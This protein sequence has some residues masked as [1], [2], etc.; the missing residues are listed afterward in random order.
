MVNLQWGRFSVLL[1]N[2]DAV[3]FWTILGYGWFSICTLYIC[4]YIFRD[5][6]LAA[7]YLMSCRRFIPIVLW[8]WLM[9]P[10]VIFTVIYLSIYTILVL[11]S[12]YSFIQ[13]TVSVILVTWHGLKECLMTSYMNAFERC[14]TTRDIILFF[15][16]CWKYKMAVISRHA[17]QLSFYF[18]FSW[19]PWCWYEYSGCF[20][21]VKLSLTIR[22]LTYKKS[23]QIM[24][25]TP[26]AY[27][28]QA[29]SSISALTN[30]R[31]IT[32]STF[33]LS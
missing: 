16:K 9:D 23:R 4:S 7:A 17:K 14:C 28:K 27:Y 30:W 25:E 8:M 3:V 26:L 20:R 5:N 13:K 29:V 33:K 6:E 1:W 32:I 19:C 31:H 24:Q 11:V 15:C 22:F 10:N 2:V 18:G 12:S 21:C